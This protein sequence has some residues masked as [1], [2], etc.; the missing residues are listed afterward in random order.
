MQAIS[1]A[2][3]YIESHFVEQI[4]LDDVAQVSGLSRFHLSRTFAAVVGLPVLAY[5]RGRRL[6]EAAR[7][8][9]DGAPDILQ[10]ALAVGYGSHEAFTR[11]FRDHFGLTP[12]EARARRSLDSLL[13]TEPPRMSDTSPA[14]VSPDRFVTSEPMF[15]AG[16]RKYFR[17]RDRGGIP[18]IW[19]AFAPHIGT[20]SGEMPGPTFGLCLGPADGADETG[21]DYMPAVQVRTLDNLAEEI[22]GV[23]IAGREWAVFRHGGHVSS[24][25]ETCAAAGDWLATSGRTPP[26]GPMQMIERYGHE[27]DPH[28]GNG[29]CEVWVPIVS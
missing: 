7:L 8:L 12:E 20:I 4:T 13:L 19:Q 1:R 22:V 16:I 9:V 3:W 25:G 14:N 5:A 18:A 23:R 6:S 17:F 27:F 11:A 10:V 26:P 29:G 2:L 28:T 24:I 15:F 21:F